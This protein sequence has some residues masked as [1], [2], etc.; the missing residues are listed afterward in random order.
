M[1]VSTSLGTGP[2]FAYS[3]RVCVGSKASRKRR[4]CVTRTIVPGNAVSAA[5]SSSIASRSRW[6]AG[7]E[8][9][10]GAMDVVRPEG[11]LGQ[12]GTRR[13]G[14]EAG[15]GRE[16]VQERTGHRKRA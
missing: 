13:F 16:C 15:S 4:S 1:V 10:A 14:R 9:R 2:I 3:E 6:F 5:S 11:E 12:Q 8:R 7:R